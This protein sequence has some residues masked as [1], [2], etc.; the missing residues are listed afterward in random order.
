MLNMKVKQEVKC[1]Y[2]TKWKVP[3]D[4]FSIKSLAKA[5]VDRE[6]IIHK[7]FRANMPGVEWVCSFIK[8]NNLT[9]RI[10]NN[11]KATRA[12][13]RNFQKKLFLHILITWNN[14]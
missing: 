6:K 4:E 3:L 9:K 8:W 10:A 14:L 2:L 1:T 5:Y 12:E 11:V 7:R 13:E